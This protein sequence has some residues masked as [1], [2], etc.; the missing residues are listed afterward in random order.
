MLT[1]TIASGASL[2]DEVRVPGG[3]AV[4][5]IQMPASWTTA[6]LTFQVSLDGANYY[7]LYDDLGGEVTVNAA[8]SRIIRLVPA[9]WWA[10]PFLKIRSG[11]SGTPV[12]QAGDRSITLY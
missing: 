4:V 10:A 11:T 8:A 3:K 9:D 12:N 1:A 5:V 7:N 6:N 2:S